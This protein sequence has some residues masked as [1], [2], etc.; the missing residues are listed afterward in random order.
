MTMVKI[1][2]LSRTNT[3]FQHTMR[4]SSALR[5]IGGSR[6]KTRGPPPPSPGAIIGPPTKRHTVFQHT[7]RA[8]SL[9]RS[10]GGSRG[11][12]GAWGSGPPPEKSCHHPAPSSAHHQNAIEMAFRWWADGGLLRKLILTPSPQLKYGG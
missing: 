4:G 11:G 8:S 3:V 6:G 10:M 7:M 9:L 2:R 12:T 1:C 5:S